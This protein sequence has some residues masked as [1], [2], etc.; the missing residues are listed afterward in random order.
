MLGPQKGL[1]FGGI[2]NNHD[3]MCVHGEENMQGR[4]C[5]RKNHDD[6]SRICSNRS[7]SFA[8][9]KTSGWSYY[10]GSIDTTDPEVAF[11]NWRQDDGSLKVRCMPR[12]VNIDSKQIPNDIRG[13]MLVKIYKKVRRLLVTSCGPPLSNHLNIDVWVV[14]FVCGGPC[15][16]THITLNLVQGKSDVL[17]V[18]SKQNTD[19]TRLCVRC[20]Y[21]AT[22]MQQRDR[23]RWRT[24]VK[25]SQSF[26]YIIIVG[27]SEYINLN[28]Q[29]DSPN[30]I[31]ANPQLYSG[32]M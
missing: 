6:Y 24:M 13:R 7:P 23:K 21:W 28:I 19:L 14:E 15:H 20:N 8:K 10:A 17:M 26:V 18:A 1:N 5:V 29:F 32:T 4:F 9:H 31:S 22:R 12:H 27:Y 2:K 3:G 25:G 11:P 16:T 30:I